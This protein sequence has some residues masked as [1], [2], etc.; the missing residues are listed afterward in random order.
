[1]VNVSLMTYTYPLEVLDLSCLFYTVLIR[2][3]LLLLNTAKR[4]FLAMPKHWKEKKER[5]VKRNA[6]E[7][8]QIR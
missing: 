7:V 3:S 5:K 8:W 1:M 4:L 6:G 2:E